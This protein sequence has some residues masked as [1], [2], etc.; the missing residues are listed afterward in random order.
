S[1][2]LPDLADFLELADV[3]GI[4]THELARRRRLERLI[5][6]VAVSDWSSYTTVHGRRACSPS[7]LAALCCARA[8]ASP[9]TST[10]VS[11]RGRPGCACRS[12]GC[13]PSVRY[14]P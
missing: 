6:S 1:R 13:R 2:D 10:D 9:A 12:R 14:P 7:A 3:E 11:W 4:Q 5:L 8:T